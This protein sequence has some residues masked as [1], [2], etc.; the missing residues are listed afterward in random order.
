MVAAALRAGGYRNAEPY[1]YRAKVEHIRQFDCIPG[2][3]AL[4]ALKR[5]ARAVA[6]GVGPSRL[7]DA[8]LLELL[9]NHLEPPAL[10]TLQFLHGNK[11]IWPEAFFVLGC[12][13]LTR[14]IEATAAQQHG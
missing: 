3:A 14:G 7:K 1:F 8:I 5:Y 9:A 11:C 4:E 10:E 2:P 6:R 12:W 13:W